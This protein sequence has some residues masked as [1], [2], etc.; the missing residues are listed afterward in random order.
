V[1][2]VDSRR[3]ILDDDAPSGRTLSRSAAS[4]KTCGSGFPRCTSSADT[5]AWKH[6]APST[7]ARIV[8]TFARGA[9][10]A[11]AWRQPSA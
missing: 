11:I 2:R 8:S 6:A 4:R 3:C 10:D 1:C 9:A 7:I 5:I